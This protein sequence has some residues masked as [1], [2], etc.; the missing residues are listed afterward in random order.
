MIN[1]F[2]VFGKGD[3]EI[4]RF[5]LCTWDLSNCN[6]F[7]EIG[8]EIDQNKYFEKNNNHV[9]EL[10][11]AAPILSE[12]TNEDNVICLAKRLAQSENSKF[13]FNDSLKSWSEI[14]EDSRNGVN[15]SFVEREELTILPI[16]IL[17]LSDKGYLTIS[18]EVPENANKWVYFRILIKTNSKTL[19][20][21]KK[22]IA[23]SKYI[24]DIRI[25]EQRNLSDIIHDAIKREHLKICNIR[26]YFCFHIVPNTYEIS[27]VDDDKLNS[28]RM[29]ETE[30]FKRY[31]ADD[32]DQKIENKKYLIAFNKWENK[33]YPD[34]RKGCS[35]FSI[36]KQER[37]GTG[38]IVLAIGANILCSL[39]FA[40][41][42]F[43]KEQGYM[44][45]I[46]GFE[47]WYR[48]MPIEY[49][50]AFSI[51]IALFVYLIPIKKFISKLFYIFKKKK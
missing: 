34:Q 3:I 39:L 40:S 29:L 1:S 13:I 48:K 38:Q 2:F 49:W 50:I 45:N 36:F 10:T 15:L 4:E 12:I 6:S 46:E 24:F 33:K 22:G 31:L 7:I 9:I 30:L 25:N 32:I 19:A 43:R 14:Q 21:P 28:V 41:A 5:H 20:L 18:I 23:S 11:I 27:F 47:S 8:A 26:T 16:E 17:K 37:L 44:Q 35:F 51:L 42:A